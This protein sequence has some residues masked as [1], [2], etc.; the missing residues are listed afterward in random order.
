VV[1]ETSLR[2]KC[3][4]CGR[5][6]TAR[7]GDTAVECNCHLYCPQ[8]TKPSDC[9]LTAVSGDYRYNWP[10]GVHFGREDEY[11]NE[12]AVSSY[13]SVHDF[14]FSK[15]EVVV[16]VDWSKVTKRAGKSERYW[17]GGVTT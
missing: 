12:H 4:R 1:D 10:K 2:V 17:G 5:Y 3:P 9:T 7:K 13:C 15:A 6:L 16:P 8:G 11:D 14:Y